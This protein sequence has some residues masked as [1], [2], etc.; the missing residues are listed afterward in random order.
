MEIRLT[1][2][3]YLLA[4]L[5]VVAGAVTL[6]AMAPGWPVA[7]YLTATAGLVTGL[8][9]S[10]AVHELAHAIAA[11]RHGSATSELAIGFFGGS[12]HA[13][14]DFTTA[15]ALGRVAAA[16][17]AASLAAALLTAAAAFGLAAEATARDFSDKSRSAA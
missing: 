15:R 3:G 12:S 4:L 8:L 13:R 11:R 2:G 1:P 16:G 17:L 7:G 9:G 10:L 5:A 6:P 14:Q